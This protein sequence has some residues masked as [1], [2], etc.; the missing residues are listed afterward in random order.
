M[1][2]FSFSLFPQANITDHVIAR[3]YRMVTISAPSESSPEHD[4]T[5]SKWALK[6]VINSNKPKEQAHC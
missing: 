4:H 5:N 6:T 3:Y 1:M 2:S